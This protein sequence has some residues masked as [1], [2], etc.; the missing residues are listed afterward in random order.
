MT[1]AASLLHFRNAAL[2]MFLALTLGLGACASQPEPQ[3]AP[4][5]VPQPEP[6]P[7][8]EPPVP[9][10]TVELDYPDGP[11]AFTSRCDYGTYIDT[12]REVHSNDRN[13][14]AVLKH[15]E[16]QAYDCKGRAAALEDYL[17]NLGA[18]D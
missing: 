14:H 6:E 9:T 18:L 3:P 11:V 12:L 15:V 2:A 4:E 10:Y 13:V 16:K 1:I 17:R 7:K 5:P 8:P